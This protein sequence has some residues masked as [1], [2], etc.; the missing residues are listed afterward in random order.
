MQHV[1]ETEHLRRVL[2]ADEVGLGK[3]VEAGLIIQHLLEQSPGL[4]VLYLAPARLVTNV[5]REFERL[6]LHFRQWSASEN[7]ANLTDPLVVASIHRAVHGSNVER[8]LS[9]WPWDVIVVDEC[10]HLSDWAAGGGDPR[11]KF[12]LV[13]DL[14]AHQPS[15]ARVIFL[16]GTPHQGHANRFEN[17]LGLLRKPDEPAEAL[18]GRVIYRTKED[19]RDWNGNPLFPTRQVNPPILVDLGPEY[20][21]WVQHIHDF[22]RPPPGDPGRADAKR[23][24]AGWRCAQALQWATSSPQAGLGYLVRQAIRARCDLGDEPLEQAIA[25]LRPYRRGPVDEPVE[26]LFKRIQREVG[27]SNETDEIEDIEEEGQN[28]T[29]EY[30]R[31]L[32]RLLAEGVRL[33]RSSA[34]EKWA[35]VKRELLDPHGDEKVVLFAQPIETVM[36][37]AQ[38]LERTSGARP[39]LIIGGQSEAEREAEVAAFWRPDGP[40]FLVSSRAGGEGI[41]LQIA[42]RLIHIDVPWNPMDMEQRVGRVH[43]FGSRRTIIVDTVVVTDSREAHA[44]RVAR[45]K[46]ELIARAL[47]PSERFEAVFSR[48]MG[49]VP[50]EELQDVLIQAAAGPLSDR[51]QDAINRMVQEGF[52]AWQ[53]FHDRFADRQRQIRQQDPGLATWE[54]VSRFLA[55]YGNVETREGF[56]ALRFTRTG[57]QVD[58]IEQPVNVVNLGDQEQYVCGD[59]GGA[60]VFGPDG[61][62][63]RQLGLN[64]PPVAE[65]LRRLAFATPA[66]AAVLRV[67]NELTLPGVDNSTPLGVLIFA[68]QTVRP[69]PRSGHIEIGCSLPCYILTADSNP[70]PVEGPLK[71][72]LLYAL[73]DATVARV[74]PEPVDQLIA[75]IGRSE[76]EIGNQLRFPSEQEM[77]SGVRH[78]V[79][80]LLAALVLR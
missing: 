72:A 45:Q 50:P 68:R 65:L 4:R 11:E 51:D 63:A 19:V 35:I 47:V 20:R 17:L 57:D 79:T 39:A 80:P 53:A 40:R 9:T 1:L 43:R 62:Q 73:F 2:V 29:R 78:A 66:G 74:R 24:A 55:E 28:E 31:A 13:R 27:P 70:V 69:D 44:Y 7:T 14:I 76:T 34:D 60:P 8:V 71:R 22:F 42:R 5:W 49:L 12:R 77:Q 41:N 46:L 75:A 21:E 33:V 15:G 36:A 6:G 26:K 3:T 23:R 54:D 67:T 56:R 32:T 48:V 58:P 59:V 30:G 10:H 37:I 38:Y 18:A 25:A 52:G 16:S 64:L 61:K